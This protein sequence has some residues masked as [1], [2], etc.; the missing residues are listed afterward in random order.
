MAETSVIDGITIGAFG[1]ACAG[2][3]VWIVQLAH[4]LINERRDKA[5]VYKWL[6]DN[7]SDEDGNR[8][9]STRAI[10]SWNN[11]AEDRV[12]Y[13]CSLHE[14]I[15]LSTGEKEDLWGVYGRGGRSAP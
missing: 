12:R 7:T 14:K 11:F 2:I 13:I 8:Y 4:T 6:R 9:R 5:R 3:T 1:G 10:S 15:Y